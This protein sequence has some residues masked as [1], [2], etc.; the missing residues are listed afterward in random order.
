M[1]PEQKA[2]REAVADAI[3]KA[4]DDEGSIIKGADAAIAVALER[5]ARQFDEM[6]SQSIRPSAAA[7]A[8]RELIPGSGS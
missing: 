3:A 5:A 1:I 8:I 2:L 7:A 4:W 6:W